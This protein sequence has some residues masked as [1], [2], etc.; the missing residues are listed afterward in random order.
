M[1]RVLI[2]LALGA[3]IACH[4]NPPPAGPAATALPERERILQM[5]ARSY[6]PGRSGQI[7]LVA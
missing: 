7:Y 2:L 4:G 5:F 1:F 6:V 3:P